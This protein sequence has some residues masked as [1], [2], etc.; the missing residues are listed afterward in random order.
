MSQ[1][2]KQIIF[3]NV[4]LNLSIGIH[5]NERAARQ[6]L[7]ISL[8][9]DVAE[10]NENDNIDNTLDYDQVFHFLKDLEKTDHFDLQETVCRKILDF[11]LGLE[12]VERVEVTTGKT[13]IYPDTD[14]VGLRMSARK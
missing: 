12:G 7:A 8:T 1:I 10:N 6:N 4:I 11:A 3:S 14:F 9:I 13:D 2:T 5:A